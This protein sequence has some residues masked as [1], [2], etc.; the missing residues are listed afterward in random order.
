MARPLVGA[1][2]ASRADTPAVF[3]MGLCEINE[4]SHPPMCVKHTRQ[5]SHASIPEVELPVA[6]LYIRLANSSPPRKIQTS[7]TFFIV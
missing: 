4:L 2:S 6:Y 1:R 3:A 5:A 7:A